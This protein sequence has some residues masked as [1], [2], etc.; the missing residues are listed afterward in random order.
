MSTQSV[1]L[2]DYPADTRTYL[3]ALLAGPCTYCH[4]RA[5]QLDHIDAQQRGGSRRWTNLAP[6]CGTCNQRKGTKSVLGFLGSLRLRPH[7]L[8]VS[9]AMRNWGAV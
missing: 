3:E 8:E 1:R 9:E 4:R 5:E 2:R 7:F 6:V